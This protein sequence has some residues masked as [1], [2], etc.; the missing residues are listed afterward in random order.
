[1][2]IFNSASSLNISVQGVFQKLAVQMLLFIGLKV[3]FLMIDK[4]VCL[5]TEWDHIIAIN[6]LFSKNFPSIHPQGFWSP[7]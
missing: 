2:H 7:P 6:D 3:T 5:S 1:M 4:L